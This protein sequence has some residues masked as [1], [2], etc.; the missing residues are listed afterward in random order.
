MGG[1]ENKV[2]PGLEMFTV[3]PLSVIMLHLFVLGIVYIFWRGPIFG[4][5]EQLPPETQSDFAK[6]IDALGESLEKTGRADYARER[7]NYYRTH[8]RRDSGVSH[9]EKK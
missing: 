2:P 8:V 9:R 4:V 7:L 3:W 6:H 1:D 5:P